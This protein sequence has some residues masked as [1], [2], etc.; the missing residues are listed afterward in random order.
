MVDSFERGSRPIPPCPAPS[1][2]SGP[3][4]GRVEGKPLNDH[5][6]EHHVHDDVDGAHKPARRPQSKTRH[7]RLLCVC[8]EIGKC[9]DANIPR[10]YANA[11]GDSSGVGFD[12]SSSVCN[13]CPHVLRRVGCEKCRR[14]HTPNFGTSALSSSVTPV[15]SEGENASLPPY[16]TLSAICDKRF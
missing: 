10:I 3:Q 6:R 1:R 11:V 14:V 2:G 9:V 15:L 13:D 16:S 4:I 7:R 12:W 8:G 5:L